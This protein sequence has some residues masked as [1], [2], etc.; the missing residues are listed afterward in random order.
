MPSGTDIAQSIVNYLKK[1][2]PKSATKSEIF[3]EIGISGCVGES[4]IKT[5]VTAR[6]IEVV[7][8][9]G[10]YNLYRYIGS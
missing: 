4:W 5:L 8:K 2:Y 7:G 1:I 9:K 6:E 3:S 10:R